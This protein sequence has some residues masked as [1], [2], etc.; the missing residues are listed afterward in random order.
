MKKHLLI[1]LYL[2]K[3]YAI[4]AQG[5]IYQMG[6]KN[7]FCAAVLTDQFKFYHA[8]Q[9]YDNWCWAA[10]I[11]MVLNY[12]GVKV[13]QKDIVKKAY[14]KIV[15][16]PADCYI[17]TRA[18]NGWDYNGMQIKAWQVS[19]VIAKDLIDALAYKYPVIIG[20]NMP[21]QEVGHAYVL[22]GI[23]FYYKNKREIPYKVILRDPWPPNK[24]KIEIEW[25][26]FKSR[27]NCIV[28]VTPKL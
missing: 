17:M 18:A 3:A 11:K 15:N 7:D 13:E 10:C 27:I 21:G 14:G 23:R 6:D 20:L 24:D 1:I 28:H 25:E 26:D 8:E 12:Q 5:E 2:I 19:N 4:N 9:E 16:E 22:T